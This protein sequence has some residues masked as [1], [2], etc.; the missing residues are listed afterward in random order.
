MPVEGRDF[1]YI[2]KISLLLGIRN[3]VLFGSEDFNCATA[4]TERIILLSCF[5]AYNPSFLAFP[6]AG[7]CSLLHIPLPENIPSIS[8]KTNQAP[9]QQQIPPHS[10]KEKT[11]K[12]EA[13]AV[14][15]VPQQGVAL[16]L[17]FYQQ[18]DCQSILCNTGLRAWTQQE[19]K[20][21][22]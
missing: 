11:T 6:T 1:Q 14:K 16:L 18:V 2:V 13:K 8:N 12:K 22:I 21:I 3:S 17:T 20:Q 10:K 19:G 7:I 9:K 4:S 5:I 15:A